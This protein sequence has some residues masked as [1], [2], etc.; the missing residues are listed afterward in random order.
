MFKNTKP[1][2]KNAPGTLTH[3][4]NYQIK[5]YQIE[6]LVKRCNKVSGWRTRV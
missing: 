3:S 5:L 1:G 2:I 4:G 6:E